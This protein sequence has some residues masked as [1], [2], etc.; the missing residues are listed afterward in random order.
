MKVTLD[1]VDG[2]VDQLVISE[3][4]LIID[5]KIARESTEIIDAARVILDYYG[6]EE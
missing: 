2:D 6:G 5:A 4:K 1:I 3:M